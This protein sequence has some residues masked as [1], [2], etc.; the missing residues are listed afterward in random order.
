MVISGRLG[1]VKVGYSM[2]EVVDLESVRGR[3]GVM[4]PAAIAS[5]QKERAAISLREQGL[6]FDEIARQL[7]FHDR[8]GAR[9]AVERGLSRWLRETDEG[10]RARELA[11]IEML[12]DR[13]WPLIDRDEPDWKAFD[14]YMKLV[15][16][17]A[18]I[19]GLFAKPRSVPETYPVAPAPTGPDKAAAT[20]RFKELT[21]GLWES[22]V[23]GGYLGSADVAYDDEE[24]DRRD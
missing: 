9:K 15:E 2:A 11:R 24:D 6:S 7:G 14:R 12:V 18:K 10:L 4:S 5:A 22:M 20:V 8:S 19:T 17:R 3:R 16:Y 21:D 1:V 23:E 13:L